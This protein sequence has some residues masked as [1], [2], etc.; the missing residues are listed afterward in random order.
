MPFWLYWLLNKAQKLIIVIL[1]FILCTKVL[2]LAGNIADAMPTP[3]PRVTAAPTPTA[4]PDDAVSW[5]SYYADKGKASNVDF[6]SVEETTSA[7]EN[8]LVIKFYLNPMSRDKDYRVAAARTII[9]VGQSIRAKNFH[10]RYD[11][12]N[13][14]FYGGFIDKYGNK[15]ESLGIRAWYEDYEFDLLNFDY[16]KGIL[17][18]DPDAIIK[19]ADDYII[20][21][22]YQD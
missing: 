17:S 7:G 16:F 20:H 6:R 5:V 22:A 19:A 18:S 13:F 21:P 4:Q 3:T 10:K 1:V 14:L 8:I 2:E 15:T 11:S 12:I 9:N